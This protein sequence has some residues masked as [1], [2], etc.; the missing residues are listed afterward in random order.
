MISCNLSQSFDSAGR[1]VVIAGV[2]EAGRGPLAGPVVAAAVILD[3]GR[4]IADLRDSKQL[5]ELKRTRIAR[6]IR[7][8]A[9]SFSLGI[10]GPREVDEFNVL[11]AS[12]LAME[13][14]VLRLGVCPDLIRVDVE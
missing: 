6:E 2:D 12:L 14:A 4:P 10:A 7:R 13:R 3:A 9:R 5:S 8:N 11:Q 1:L